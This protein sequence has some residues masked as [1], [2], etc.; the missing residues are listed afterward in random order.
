MG[1]G[2]VIAVC[3]QLNQVEQL[4]R[5]ASTAGD[6]LQVALC[7]VAL[8]TEMPPEIE[9]AWDDSGYW[10]LF[11]PSDP[12]V[13]DDAMKACMTVISDAAAMDNEE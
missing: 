8:G 11:D 9:K 7:H 6:F 3:K 12:V 1:P 10:D 13:Q 5:E 2:Q 4:A